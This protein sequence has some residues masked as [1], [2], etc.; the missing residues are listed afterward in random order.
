MSVAVA[1]QAERLRALFREVDTGTR[2]T[3]P[4]ARSGR[5]IA[6]ASGKGGVGKTTIA[7]SLAVILARRGRRVLLADADLGTANIDVLLNLGVRRRLSNVARGECSAADAVITVAP[8]LRFLP[9]AAG[10]AG[11][12]DLGRRE[13]LALV[14]ELVGMERDA[15]FLLLDCGAGISRNVT[16]FAQAADDLLVVT[17]PEPAAIT[18]AYSLIKV[19]GRRPAAPALQIIVN[20]AIRVAEGRAVG[21]RIRSVAQRFLSVDVACAGCVLYDPELAKCARKGVRRLD[22]YPPPRA[23]HGVSML[24]EALDQPAPQPLETGSF[25]QRVGRLFY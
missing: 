22:R 21:D 7:L 10:V 25:F 11:I 2:R 13:R 18:G 24:A 8:G 20:Q 14:D 6:V 17:T 12:A 16:A 23:A 9:G 3:V 5:V 4:A 15:D 1:D 19:V